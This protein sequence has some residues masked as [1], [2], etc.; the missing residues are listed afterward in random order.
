MYRDIARSLSAIASGSA[1]G[2]SAGA[3]RRSIASVAGRCV[4]RSVK[5]SRTAICAAPSRSG[6]KLPAYPAGRSLA[7][8]ISKSPFGV[9]SNW[10]MSCWASVPV[11]PAAPRITSVPIV[12]PRYGAPPRLPWRQYACSG[13]IATNQ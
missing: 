10:S 4:R 3:P 8:R 13:R 12:K 7:H 1:R 9:A 2:G 5:V 6:M 11:R